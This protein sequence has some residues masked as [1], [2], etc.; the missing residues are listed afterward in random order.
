[1]IISSLYGG[2]GGAGGR[3]SVG[4]IIFQ[5]G[6]VTLFGDADWCG[7]Y[8]FFSVV[9]QYDKTFWFLSTFYDNT[10]NRPGAHSTAIHA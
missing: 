1:M 10:V 3:G 4:C 9:Q 6:L 7:C 5:S 8:F 2:G